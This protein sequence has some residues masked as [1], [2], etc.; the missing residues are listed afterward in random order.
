MSLW[1]ARRSWAGTPDRRH[2]RAPCPGPVPGRHHAGAHWPAAPTVLPLRLW[3]C[4]GAAPSREGAA[5]CPKGRWRHPPPLQRSSNT[6][7]SSWSPSPR[8]TETTAVAAHGGG[9][10]GNTVPWLSSRPSLGPQAP[11]RSPWESLPGH[12]DSA[13]HPG[14]SVRFHFLGKSKDSTQVRPRVLLGCRC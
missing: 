9:L 13:T 7:A 5:A 4:R 14:G 10:L 3:S 6:G 2:P 12:S 11:S 8:R 1:E